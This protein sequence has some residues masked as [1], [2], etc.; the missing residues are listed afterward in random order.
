MLNRRFDMRW[1]TLDRVGGRLT[2][3]HLLKEES[4][5]GGYDSHQGFFGVHWEV[6]EKYPRQVY[7]HVESPKQKDNH[8]L[9]RIKARIIKAILN[10]DIPDLAK[11]NGLDYQPGSRIDISNI[12]NYK[13]T[14]VFSIDFEKGDKPE[15]LITEVNGVLGA[16]IE[17]IISVYKADI[18]KLVLGK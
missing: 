1:E 17:E 16:R 2:K 8:S 9:N 5:F 10:S 14:G 7:L 18:S 4:A 6:Q 15:K 11:E 13:S 12:S 3:G